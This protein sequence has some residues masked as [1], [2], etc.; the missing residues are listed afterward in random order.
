MGK[1]QKPVNKWAKDLKRHATKDDRLQISI[2]NDTQQCFSGK[3]FEIKQQSD[4]STHLLK[5]SNL[6]Y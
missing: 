2:W 3:N 4:I 1:K 6:K 5:M